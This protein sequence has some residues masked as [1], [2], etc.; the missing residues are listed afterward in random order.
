M[1]AITWCRAS[2]WPQESKWKNEGI[3][4]KA[5]LRHHDLKTSQAYLGKVSIKTNAA[6]VKSR[7]AALAALSNLSTRNHQLTDQAAIADK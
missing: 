5:I 4:S 6:D 3:V 2:W 1:Q 7:A